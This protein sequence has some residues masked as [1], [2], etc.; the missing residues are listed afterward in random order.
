[1]QRQFLF[2]SFFVAVADAAAATV[3]CSAM[4]N[5]ALF[6]RNLPNNK[7]NEPNRDDKP[8]IKKKKKIGKHNEID[9][10]LTLFVGQYDSPNRMC[11][12]NI[13]PTSSMF[14]SNYV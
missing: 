1:M 6:G 12:K 3:K 5:C 11:Q 8:K 7:I 9:R 4:C 2:N 13:Q 10:A 14:L